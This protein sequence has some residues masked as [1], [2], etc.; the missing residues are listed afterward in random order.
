MKLNL[1][2]VKM[3]RERRPLWYALNLFHG[4]LHLRE[5][6]L[7]EIAGKASDPDGLI[8]RH[9]LAR[10]LA[11]YREQVLP[12]L[13]RLP[14]CV[15]VWRVRYEAAS[16]LVQMLAAN[17]MGRPFVQLLT[18]LVTN[19]ARARLADDGKSDAAARRQ[20]R[21]FLRAQLAEAMDWLV[22][23]D[24]GDE[25]RQAYELYERLGG[26]TSARRADYAVWL[27]RAGDRS[28]AA[29]RV[30]LRHLSERNGHS[31]DDGELKEMRR[32]VAGQLA[33]GEQTS[34]QELHRRMAYNQLAL[35]GANPPPQAA[36]HAGLCYIR[37][38]QPERAV[39]YLR[40][41]RP[42]GYADGGD[43]SFYLGQALFQVGQYEQAAVA[44]EHAGEEG[45]SLSRIASWQGVAYA[46]IRQWEK[47]VKTFR[48][49]EQAAGVELDS[50]FYLQWGRAS[51]L[52]KDTSDAAQRFRRSMA[53]DETNWRAAY[54]L[55]VCL[56]QQGQRA[57][58][59][60][61][62]RDV[63]AHNRRENRP[64]APVAHLLG[65]LLEAEGRKAEASA[66]YREALA[67]CPDDTEY[68]LSLGLVLYDLG[69]AEGLAL[70]ERVARARK[71][72]AEV[73]RRVAIGYFRAGERT[74]GRR[75]LRALAACG[76]TD[77]A[78]TL[79]GLRDN[80]SEATAAFNAG[81]Y[82]E[83]AA[84]WEEVVAAWPPEPRTEA[85]VRRRLALALTYEAAT[86][87]AG[88]EVEGIWE[89][90]DRAQSLAPD[91]QA[92]LLSGFSHLARGDFP[93]A[94]QSFAALAD[95]YPEDADYQFFR[96][97]ATY[98]AGDEGALERLTPPGP[99]ARSA[100][101]GPLLAYL[102]VQSAALTGDFTR[103]AER[104]KVWAAE[105][106]AVR[107]LG[108]PRDQINT[109]AALCLTRGTRQRKQHVIRFIEE[110][111]TSYG[112]GYWDLALALAKHHI[113]AA[114][115]DAAKLDECA[116]A[117][118]KLLAEAAGRAKVA[119]HY[120][121][122][123]R[124]MVCQRLS[125]GNI[126]DARA[127]LEQ[128]AALPLEQPS[129]VQELGR[130]LDERLSAPSHEKAYALLSSDPDGA[131]EVWEALLGQDGGN[132]N[133]TLQHL[134]CLSWSRAYDAVV[135][136]QYDES[137]P[138]WREGLE[139]YRRLYARADYW[140]QLR[141]KGRVLG[142]MP[143]YPFH[144]QLF[145]KWR[146][147]ALYKTARTLLDLITHVMA[148]YDPAKHG[149]QFNPQVR[150]ARSLMEIVRQ[151]QL[152]D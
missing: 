77:P 66:Y 14:D 5:G 58:A 67:L 104:L 95:D 49:A 78:I 121:G 146:A 84:L 70:L 120:A 149:G 41:P 73:L 24:Q 71:G 36:R 35:C 115:S 27:W 142:Q 29:V 12:A 139:W 96:H 4:E 131:K 87:F 100:N 11:F 54:G 113:A 93:A 97:L 30:Y 76:Q 6:S 140:E 53:R 148:G 138:F 20:A 60:D 62:L 110:Q 31:P 25:A 91:P 134:A 74:R 28:P 151:S 50:E 90:V 82:T 111:N 126:G 56:E 132:D 118:R 19:L 55:A 98:F 119:E 26:M 46:K 72:G 9:G 1:A 18:T 45:C 79:F 32:L 128:L 37:L 144:E 133:V 7:E 42:P 123:L 80:A 47:A 102:Q 106:D 38:G 88:G 136:R 112:E 94:E 99:A 16:H 61:L 150:T 109:L 21:H 23:S 75:W 81:Q 124:L 101:L 17:R 103:A 89:Q 125:T 122:L 48:L 2:E 114:T 44:F 117:Y 15:E 65:R 116:A 147:E 86:R 145:D 34:P 152:P 57:E 135:A 64:D 130:L 51:F 137:L 3:A 68:M 105:P 108:L 43:T 129:E 22:V 40:R 127:M 63:N 92:R 52:M 33:V 8:L 13:D 85:E 59:T 39:D 107:G 141:E 83:A 143:G 69:E 10:A